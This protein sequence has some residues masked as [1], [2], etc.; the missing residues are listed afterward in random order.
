MLDMGLI[1][2]KDGAPQIKKATSKKAFMLI[3]SRMIDECEKNGATFFDLI[4]NTD[5][6]KEGSNQ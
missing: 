6:K 1:F 3:I 5:V 4:V 2:D